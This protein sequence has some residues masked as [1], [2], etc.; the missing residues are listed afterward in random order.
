MY[1][2]PL[3]YSLCILLPYA[4]LHELP[5]LHPVKL[6]IISINLEINMELNAI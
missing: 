2:V 6:I 4:A 1:C 5:K 3:H